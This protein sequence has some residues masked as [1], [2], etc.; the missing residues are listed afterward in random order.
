MRRHRHPL[1]ALRQRRPE[2]LR[3]ERS[4]IRRQRLDHPAEWRVGRL[5][6]A[7]HLGRQAAGHIP[8]V[9]FR[10]HAAAAAKLDSPIP[11][12]VVAVH[13]ET[14][15]LLACRR[16]VGALQH[17]RDDLRLGGE[18]V[19]AAPILEACRR[20]PARQD[21]CVQR[22]NPAR[23]PR[24]WSGMCQATAAAPVFEPLG[25]RTTR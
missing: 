25:A 5:E 1:P 2:Q 8:V 20:A 11:D 6:Q 21:V 9:C 23:T 17:A 18:L 4:P 24:A 7:I 3:G 22:L 10:Q 13:L 15:S 14:L 12:V 19:V 16:F